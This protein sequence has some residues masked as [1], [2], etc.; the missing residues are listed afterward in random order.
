MYCGHASGSTLQYVENAIAKGIK[1]IG[2]SDHLGRYYLTT[3][4]KRRYWDWG[5][6]ERYIGRYFEELSGL[7]STFE[8]SITIKIGLEIDFIEGADDLLTPLVSNYEF[9][10]FL[11][12]VHCLPRFG[13]KHLADYRSTDAQRAFTEYFR[14]LRAAI[15]SRLFNSIA[16]P[17]FI[18]RYIPVTPEL[19][20][21]II[22]ELQ[23]TVKTALDYNT[24]LEVNANSFLWS[25]MNQP[26][27]DPFLIMLD[28][29][30]ES[31]ASITIGSDAHEPRNV[32]KS[33]PEMKKL[34]YSKNILQHVIFSRMAQIVRNV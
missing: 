17:D 4:Q 24:P 11:G 14:L 3:T 23:L 30:A 8:D 16:H 6:H 26:V 12:S 25:S 9:D 2:F 7:K 20:E 27:F 22:N 5:M 13:W 29:I 28:M 18:F 21:Y 34:L 19:Q 15:T 33:F 32:A 10:F 31:G 1:E